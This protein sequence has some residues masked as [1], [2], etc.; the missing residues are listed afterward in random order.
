MVLL[1]RIFHNDENFYICAVQM[2]VIIYIWVLRR[3]KIVANGTEKLNFKFYLLINKY[4]LADVA[5]G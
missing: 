3:T 2:A 5:T 1:Y 4:K